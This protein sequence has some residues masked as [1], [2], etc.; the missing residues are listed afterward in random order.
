MTQPFNDS[1]LNAGFQMD[2]SLLTPEQLGH[3]LQIFEARGVSVMPLNEYRK[4]LAYFGNNLVTSNQHEHRDS[5]NMELTVPVIDYPTLCRGA[6]QLE[7]NTYAIASN[8]KICE[9]LQCAQ[10]LEM[11]H[12]MVHAL[13][14]YIHI[15]GTGLYPSSYAN[16]GKVR[17]S[18]EDFE[19]KLRGIYPVGENNATT[20][21]VVKD[22]LITETDKPRYLKCKTSPLV[23]KFLRNHQYSDIH[24]EGEVVTPINNLEAGD[25][26]DRFLISCFEECDYTPEPE[27]S[28]SAGNAPPIIEFVD[29]PAVEQAKEPIPMSDAEIRRAFNSYAERLE[30]ENAQLS[31]AKKEV[32]Q[33]YTSYKFITEELGKKIGVRIENLEA[34]NARYADSILRH[35]NTIDSQKTEIKEQ[36]DEINRLKG[37]I[38]DTD[39]SSEPMYDND[40]IDKT[41]NKYHK[42]YWYKGN[43]ICLVS[44][45][46]VE[47]YVPLELKAS[48][49]IIVRATASHTNT[50][51]ESDGRKWYIA[52]N[53]SGVKVWATDTDHSDACNIFT[54]TQSAQKAITILNGIDPQILKNYLS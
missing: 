15:D 32:E 37:L 24:F 23:V 29:S 2:T 47:G 46:N 25:T 45:E 19:R 7:P 6:V 26:S 36:W 39:N 52:Q 54:S 16:E 20:E 18:P 48:A 51:F 1:K 3:V 38:G 41:I 11:G 53:K 44:D 40:W 50:L 43:G 13:D 31:K 42:N 49:D 5:V 34:E 35:Q 21:P 28:V 8:E 27:I 4:H 10:S 9:L 12:Y 17:I 30:Q 14:N 33:D 22:C